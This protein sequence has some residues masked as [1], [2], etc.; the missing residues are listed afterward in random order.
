MSVYV[1]YNVV[2]MFVN[3]VMCD[4]DIPYWDRILTL[5]VIGIINEDG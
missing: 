4:W 1:L 5:V 3:D 2:L